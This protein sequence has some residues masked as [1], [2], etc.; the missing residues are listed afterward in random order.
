VVQKRTTINNVRTSVCMWGLFT[1]VWIYYVPECKNVCKYIYNT[2]YVSIQDLRMYMYVGLCSHPRI[3]LFT[4]YVVVLFQ[5]QDCLVSIFV[6]NIHKRN[7]N[8]R[9]TGIVQSVRQLDNRGFSLP[10]RQDGSCPMGTGSS[11][12]AGK[13]AG[14]NSWPHLHL[15]PRLEMLEAIPPLPIR[16]H[17]VVLN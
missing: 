11:L 13:A 14:T 3:H 17:G 7:E 16:L 2:M 5:V 4:S 1:Y 9:R 8:K 6:S 10:Q 15:V 12:P